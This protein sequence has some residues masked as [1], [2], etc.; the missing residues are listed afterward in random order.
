MLPNLS[1]SPERNRMNV[2]KNGRV[3][4]R[5]R[6][7]MVSAIVDEGMTTVSKSVRRF[8]KEGRADLRDR[9]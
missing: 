1:N 5:G 4:P 3:T 2:H 8:R 6:E 9:S 7:A